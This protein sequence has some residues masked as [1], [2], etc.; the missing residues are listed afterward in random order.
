MLAKL[1]VICYG[2]AAAAV[3]IYYN[4]ETTR[5]LCII[6]YIDIAVQAYKDKARNRL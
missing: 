2:V 1:L 6:N 5:L 4:D 3:E